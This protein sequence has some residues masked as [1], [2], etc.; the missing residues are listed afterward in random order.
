MCKQ[1]I[2][3][4]TLAGQRRVRFGE[5]IRVRY[6]TALDH[7]EGLRQNIWFDGREMRFMKHE[8]MHIGQA[9]ANPGL[10]ALLTDVYGREDPHTMQAMEAWGIGCGHRRG[11]ERF[12]SHNYAVR[13]VESR[14]K[15]SLSVLKAQERMRDVEKLQDTL[16]ISLVIGRLSLALSKKARA[17]ARLY[18]IVD[19]KV[20]ESLNSSA[21][22]DAVMMTDDE[23]CKTPV[24][25]VAKKP[26]IV[27]RRRSPDSI[28]DMQMHSAST[29][30][31]NAS[32]PQSM[33]LDDP[34]SLEMVAI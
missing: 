10:S 4:H 11:L 24:Q 3:A 25:F 16:Y 7:P 1:Q 9:S 14:K 15:H 17:F 20:L 22:N 27:E 28:M 8:A 2:T 33:M 6:G 12:M 19:E 5:S 26:A 23:P 29:F 30:P 18:G 13:R 32:Y 31:S 21:S 34:D